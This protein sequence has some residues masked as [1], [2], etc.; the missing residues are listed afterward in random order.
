MS[1][2]LNSP[3]YCLVN[4][5]VNGGHVPLFHVDV[6]EIRHL[7]FWRFDRRGIFRGTLI[8]HRYGMD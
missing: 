2:I 8:E 4:D 1:P 6:T 3:G 5:V 7:V